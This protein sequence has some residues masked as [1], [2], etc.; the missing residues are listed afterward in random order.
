MRL[1]MKPDPGD[2]GSSDS[3]GYDSSSSSSRRRRRR[4]D[5]DEDS[6]LSY[7]A[8]LKRKATR[9]PGSVMDMLVKNAQ[10]QMDRGSLLEQEGN[11]PGVTSGIK[12][13]TYFALM[14]R[15]Y[16]QS[17][18]PLLRELYALGQT[19][20]LLR[21]GRLPETADALASR[22][23]AVHT[24]L[25]EGG[26]GT[27]AQL[28]LYPLEPVQSAS[29]ST[30]LQAQKHKRLLQKSQGVQPNRWWPPAGGKGKGGGQWGE[31]GRKG[32]GKGKTKGKGKGAAKDGT[33]PKKTD[34]NPWKDS[35]DDAAKK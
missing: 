31:K 16:Y 21:S 1:R 17:N 29:V 13:S 14:I 3:S 5:S 22:F 28:E 9:E 11:Q 33:W 20:D 6:E 4:R 24:A 7:E 35:Q 27:A 18:S 25:A 32:D 34:P 26:W 2:P 8:P 19:I 12:I 30:M 15:P 10:D 23:I